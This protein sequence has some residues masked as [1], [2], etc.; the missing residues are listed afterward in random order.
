MRL[1]L[2]ALFL[3]LFWIHGICVLGA[4][5]ELKI[6][7]QGKGKVVE[8]Q[9]EE[10]MHVEGKVSGFIT[11]TFIW[12]EEHQSAPEPQE[13]AEKG[14]ITITDRNGDTVRLSFSGRASLKETEEAVLEGANGSFT[15]LEGTGSWAGR[16]LSGT[17]TKAGVFKNGSIELSITLTAKGY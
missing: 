2:G 10:R 11:G 7:L 12:E 16:P 1:L 8:E 13:A 17:Y 4:Q 9:D 6:T 14:T 15:Y 3:C 5:E